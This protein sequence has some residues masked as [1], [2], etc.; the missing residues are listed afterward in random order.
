[1]ILR[2]LKHKLLMAA[3]ISSL[4]A[5]LMAAVSFYLVAYFSFR[6][7]MQADLS[8][9]AQ[10]VGNETTA[11]IAYNDPLTARENL[12]DMAAQKQGVLAACIYTNG[13]R[14]AGYMTRQAPANILPQHPGVEGW[15]YSQHH[16]T[17]FEPI[18]LNGQQVGTLYVCSDLRALHAMMSRYA[19]IILVFVCGSLMTAYLLA[20]RLQRYILRSVSHLIHTME[21]VTTAKNYSVRAVRQTDDEMGDLV[22]GFNEMLAQIQERDRALNGA[23]EMLERRV[24]ERTADLQQQLDR[25]SLLNQITMAVAARQHAESIVLVVLQKLAVN[26]PMDFSSAYWYAE[27]S[28]RLKQMACDVKYAELPRNVPILAGMEW[29]DSPFDPCLKGETVYLA[30]V[31]TSPTPLARALAEA[32]NQSLLAVPLHLDGRLLGLLLFLRKERNGFNS[33]DLEFL[34][35]LST[36]VALAVRQ[37]Q[38]YQD[39][40]TAY[41]ELHQTQQ[42]VMQHER[43][44]ALGQMASGIAHDINNALSPIVGFS[45]LLLRME[46]ALSADGRKYL[47][48]IKTAGEDISHIVAGL[49]EFYRLRHEDEALMP[50]DLNGVVN[51]VVDMTRPKWRDLPQ[52]RGVMI[53][54]EKDLAQDLPMICGIQS[55]VREAL[56]NLLLNAVD[57]MP[58]G[59]SL[60]VRTRMGSD[61]VILEVSDTGIGMDEST[62]KRCLEPFFSTKGK[63]GTGLGLAMVYGIMERHE[64]HIDVDSAPG[65]GTTMRLLFPLS[66]KP[67][68]SAPRMESSAKPSPLRILCIDD[69]TTIRRLMQ[70]MLQHDGHDVETAESG[71]L[72]IGAFEKARS[73][74]KPFDVVITDLGMPHMDGRE[75]AQALKKEDPDL[76][77][78]MLTGWGDFISED[79]NQPVDAILAKPPRL[80]EIRHRLQELVPN[81]QAKS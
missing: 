71:E 64:G 56:T 76:P 37:A 17:G 25:I 74:G 19:T 36:H 7:G 3:I 80:N 21:G 65:R 29:A 33:G 30:D 4:T 63:R 50:L 67:S 48:Y 11:A 12:R 2:S 38:L 35:S 47:S 68:E 6:D 58:S 10:I 43:L 55:E 27:G 75:V 45:D 26:L 49:K 13:T 8:S 44:K 9:L 57:A 81:A 18:W 70:E 52:R 53:E 60:H 78:F 31:T 40:Q 66:K 54:M 42:T 28:G 77:V 15:K 59:G 23:N 14:F 79:K 69:E 1:M 16:L 62:R 72:G 5:L 73:H 32:G 34:Q 46:T 22:E 39:L 24:A 61:R 20:S 51:Q 41:Q